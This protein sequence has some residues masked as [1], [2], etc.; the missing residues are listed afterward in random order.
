MP[1]YPAET[2][3]QAALIGALTGALIA[4]ALGYRFAH[5]NRRGK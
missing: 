5:R 2:V 4:F 3:W 1:L